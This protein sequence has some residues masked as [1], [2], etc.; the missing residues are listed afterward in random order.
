MFQFPF[1]ALLALVVS[2]CCTTSEESQPHARALLQTDIIVSESSNSNSNGRPA[3]M[4]V[5]IY[6]LES[7][8]GFEKADFQSLRDNDEKVLGA[9]L[10]FKE[11]RDAHPGTRIPI[12]QKLRETARYLGVMVDF[13]DFQNA[14]WRALTKLPAE[15]GTPLT[16]EIGDSSVSVRQQRK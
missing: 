1:F 3:P 5:R 9:D 14:K 15:S 16:I 10:L 4:T 11:E 8:S 12:K 6:Q 7:G 13:R 2:G